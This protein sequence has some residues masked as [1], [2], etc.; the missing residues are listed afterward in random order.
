MNFHRHGLRNNGRYI[1]RERI[2]KG[3]FGVVYKAY[4]TLDVEESIPLAIKKV[5]NYDPIHEGLSIPAIRELCALRRA[6]HPNLVTLYDSFIERSTVH[7][8]FEYVPCDLRKMIRS[9]SVPPFTEA[10]IRGYARMLLSGIAYLHDELHIVHLDIKPENLLIAFDSA[11]GR[12]TLKIGDFGTSSYY[13]QNR[14]AGLNLPGIDAQT[15]E[16]REPQ[17]VTLWYRAPELLY[18]AT[19]YDT[20]VDMWSCGCVIAELV[21]RKPLFQGNSELSVLNEISS[22]LG[23]PWDGIWPG[24]ASFSGSKFANPRPPKDFAEAFGYAPGAT[25]AVLG[26]AQKLVSYCPQLRGRAA[27]VLGNEPLF[28]GVVDENETL[29]LPH[30]PPPGEVEEMNAPKR[31]FL[32]GRKPFLEQ[33]EECAVEEGGDKE[34]RGPL[35]LDDIF[36][37]DDDNTVVAMTDAQIDEFL[38]HI[39]DDC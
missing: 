11:T 28:A 26:L 20:A 32:S 10:Q 18:G 7:L 38:S 19:Q 17:A 12:T 31:I 1:K 25:P 39:N 6:S 33:L 13:G 29:L 21:I 16:V 37:D 3:G 4:L 24:F 9:P 14:A 8:V 27:E 30:P 5:P 22:L 36:D 35:R 34:M 2:G 23:D 15:P